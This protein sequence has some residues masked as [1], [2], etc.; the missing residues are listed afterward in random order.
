MISRAEKD[1]EDV[2]KP[3]YYGSGYGSMAG[4]DGDLGGGLS[5]TDIIGL[6]RRR[7][8]IIAVCIILGTASVAIW[9]YFQRATYTAT[10]QLLIEPEHRVVDLDSVVKGVGSDAATIETQLSLFKSRGFLEGF[11]ST[12]FSGQASASQA[13]EE[14]G[15]LKDDNENGPSKINAAYAAEPD[16]P[17]SFYGSAPNVSEKAAEIAGRLSVSQQGR[18]FIINVGYTSPQP[19]EAARLANEL[20]SYYIDEQVTRRRDV[21]GDAS[22]FLEE[23]LKELEAELL[24]AEEALHRY[25]SE[26]QTIDQ[27]TTGATVERLSEIT[28]LLV[29]T[30]ANRKEKEARLEYMRGLKKKG[31]RLDSLTEVL[32][33]RYMASLWDEDSALRSREAELRL[34]L[35]SSHP[36]I[37]ALNEERAELRSRIDA[38]V[39]KII[40]NASNELQVLIEREKSLEEDLAGLSDLA[41]RS[42]TSSDHAAIRLRLLVGKAET[43]RRIYEE[44]LIRLKQTR[45]QEGIVQAN[46][47]LVASAIMPLMPSSSGP[48]RFVMLGLVG[49]SAIGFGLAYLLDKLDRRLRTANEVMQSLRVPCLGLVPFVSEKAR[50]K[51]KLP[52]YLA[53]KRI[54]RFAEALR[55]IHT[56]VVIGN[57]SEKPNKVFQVTSSVPDEGKTTF[58]VNLATLLAL[59]GKKAL[60]LDLD[61]RNPS[62]HREVNLEDACSIKPYLRNKKNY[63]PSMCAKLETGL[64]V[65]ALKAPL[66]DPGKVLQSRNIKN[67][68]QSARRC[69]DYIVIDGPPSLGLSDSKNLLPLIDSLIFIIRWNDTKIEQ[70]SDAIEELKR[71]NASIAGA[72]LTQVDLKRQQR[73]G[74]LG[75]SSSYSGNTS[76]YND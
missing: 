22:N 75:E 24:D 23:R 50:G 70:A 76:Y 52:E 42:E 27:R 60:L 30:R 1:S 66:N 67:L 20:A 54:S 46:T 8:E 45:E 65:I 10:A 31:A 19:Q 56:Q 74:Y 69:Y 35:G 62:I 71:C 40:D 39:D 18:S 21:T 68:I 72:V 38:E 28:S 17:K 9:S 61:L 3:V 6:L 64:H 2:I 57:D 15:R 7:W 59:D 4:D 37:V 5:L 55:S 58:A 26:N 63:D 44:F 51:E 16:T 12:Q 49:S 14:L 48:M 29:Q 33:S 32:S 43:S 41:S 25:R 11:V 47:R 34:E 73:Y 13:S 53:S 36:R